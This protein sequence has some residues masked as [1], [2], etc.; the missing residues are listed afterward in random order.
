MALREQAYSLLVV[1]ASEKFND[2]MASLLP[3]MSFS[4]VGFAGSISEA[5]RKSAEQSFDIIVVNSPLADDMGI[6]FAI[7][8]STSSNALVLILAKNETFTDV[9]EKVERYGVFTLSKPISKQSIVNALRWMI[10]YSRRNS[11]SLRRKWRK[12]AL[13]TRQNGFLSVRK[14]SLNPK[15]TAIS[16]RKLWTAVFR[17]ES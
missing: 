16:K 17:S 13:L 10:T 12:S 8:S 1:S 15:L 4:P 3:E 14:V 5:Q 7:D 9:Y 2:I 11:F 6:R